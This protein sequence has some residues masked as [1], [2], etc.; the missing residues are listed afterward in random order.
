[1]RILEKE[2]RKIKATVQNLLDNE[3]Q[4]TG[5]FIEKELDKMGLKVTRTTISD[6]RTKKR[7]LEKA[8]FET[9]SRLYHF[10]K[11]HEDKLNKQ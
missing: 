3:N 9:I 4:F 5:Y 7:S 1:M 2:T 11:I 6:L 10:A 8:S